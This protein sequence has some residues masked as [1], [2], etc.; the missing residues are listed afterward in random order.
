M[1]ETLKVNLGARSYPIHFGADLSAEVREEIARLGAAGRKVAVL[2][3]QN[4]TRAQANALNAMFGT[5]P[6]LAVEPGEGS[7]SLA[8][9]GR[10]LGFLAEQKLD[11]GG[12]L[13]AVGGGVIGDLGGFAAASW[14]RGID[15]FQVPTTLLAMVDSSVGGKTGI[16]LKA[17]K[18]LAGAYHQPRGV[19]ISTGLLST[20]PSREFA[21]GMAEVI[22]YGLLGDAELF[23]SLE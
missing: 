2:T 10:V 15:F 11:R 4:F 19:F 20:L 3:D 1:V 13:F 8:G 23:E 5:A 21:A 7:K 17:G 12:A 16:N 9:L 6:V 14:L 18:K 22:K